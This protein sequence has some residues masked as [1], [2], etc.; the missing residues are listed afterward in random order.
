MPRHAR[1]AIRAA[2]SSW[3]MLPPPASQNRAE[4]CAIPTSETAARAY[5]QRCMESGDEGLKKD[6]QTAASD[7]TIQAVAQ[8]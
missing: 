8:P 5:L 4:T 6:C 7:A 1:P 2:A 3:G